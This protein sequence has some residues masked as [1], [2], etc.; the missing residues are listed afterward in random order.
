MQPK[1]S[2]KFDEKT[3][4][5]HKSSIRN[6]AIA[7]RGRKRKSSF[8]APIPNDVGIQ[9]TRRC[10]LRCTTCFLWNE[11][12][13][14]LDLK[15]KERDVELDISVIEKIFRETR[16]AKSKLY[17]WGAE[18]LLHKNWEDI[19]RLLEK[20]PRW[21]VVCTNGILIDKKMES[22]LRVS[23]N[24]AIVV[25]LD[26]FAEEHNNIR[27][28]NAFER[29]MNNVN[30]LLDMQRKNK[31]KGVISFH[32]VLNDHII[33]KIYE[34]AEYCESYGVDSLYFG[35]PWYISEETGK[36]MDDYFIKNFSWLNSL[37]EITKPSWYYYSYHIK[38]SLINTLREQIKKLLNRKLKIRIRLQPPLE[39]FEFEDYLIGNRMSVL[40][41]SQCFS[42]SN[43][44]DILA[45][46][47]VTA[48][49]PFSEFSVGNLYEKG[50]I[51]I[52]KSKEYNRLRETIGKG[53]TPI[54][55]KCILLFLNGK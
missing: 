27:G 52:W 51:E 43:R 32:C 17:M 37:N 40:A 45:D 29:T 1:T 31:Y 54:C 16:E 30:L 10:N 46:G 55:S 2:V 20:D 6:L 48:C 5:R 9:V 50:L 4:E 39:I 8:A 49:Q 34:F 35:F 12:G 13:A 44:T 33:P 25:S 19:T 26:G 15:K 36:Q 47:S 23:E 21:T 11:E 7:V 24:L 14:F 3:F 53:L 42:V 38:P 41:R 18:P 22:I 28:K